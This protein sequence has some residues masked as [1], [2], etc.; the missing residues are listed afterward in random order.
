[1]GK[2]RV[3]ASVVCVAAGNLLVVRLRDP[4]TGFVALYPPGGGIEPGEPAAE[5]ARRETLEETGFRVRVD[6]G[7]ELV[8]SYPF[9]WAGIDYDV[10]THWF[11]ARL[12]VPFG[13]PPPIIDAAYNLGALWVPVHEV[14]EAMSVHP[15]I[16][17]A[18]ERLLRT[19]PS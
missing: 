1:M 11:V 9:C 5:T 10:T 2:K 17:A 6:P 16:A 15:P 8:T 13:P 18:V 3:R 7:T 19:E 12:E 4:V 14:L